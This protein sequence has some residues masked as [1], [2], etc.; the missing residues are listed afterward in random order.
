MIK[1]I[2]KI[3]AVLTVIAGALY[4]IGQVSQG[5]EKSMETD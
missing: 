4:F 5:K 1:L 2:I 3:G